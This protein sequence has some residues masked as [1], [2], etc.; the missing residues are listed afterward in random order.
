MVQ[1]GHQQRQAAVNFE[2][3]YLPLQA[4]GQNLDQLRK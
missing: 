3:N 2:L 1:L 4:L